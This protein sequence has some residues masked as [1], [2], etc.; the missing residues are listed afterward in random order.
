LRA[1]ENVVLVWGIAAPIVDVTLLGQCRLLGEIVGPVQFGDV[2]RDG[3]AFGIHP[4]PFA[5]AI[6]GVYSSGALRRQVGVPGF[7]ARSGSS[8]KLLTMTISAVE[9]A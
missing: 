4:R 2:L 8:R 7:R 6:A 9:S 3:H 1:G 5:N